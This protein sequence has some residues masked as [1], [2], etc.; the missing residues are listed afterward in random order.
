MEKNFDY[1]EAFN[2]LQTYD[3]EPG[4]C[5]VREQPISAS[6]IEEARR[7]LDELPEM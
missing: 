5:Y 4:T 2:N 6:V 3:D 1:L 7:I